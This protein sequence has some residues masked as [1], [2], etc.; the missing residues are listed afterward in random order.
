MASIMSVSVR[1]IAVTSTY[2]A[3]TVS[4]PVPPQQG[5]T[6]QPGTNSVVCYS[7]SSTPDSSGYCLQPS[8]T[9]VQGQGQNNPG[10]WQSA[11]LFDRQPEEHSSIASVREETSLNRHL[12]PQTKDCN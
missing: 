9:R 1:P 3:T 11:H 6:L 8:T 7:N 12:D 2:P 4:A 10:Q 5:L